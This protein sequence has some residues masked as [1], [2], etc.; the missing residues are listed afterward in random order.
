MTSDRETLHSALCA[1][2][3]ATVDAATHTTSAREM[4]LLNEQ[5]AQSYVGLALNDLLRKRYRDA[6]G[7]F[8][9]FETS[10]T[11]LDG[12]LPDYVRS[13]PRPGGLR[14]RQR[15]DVVVWSKGGG[16]AGLVELK[17]TPVMS[18][19]AESSDPRKLCG[20]LRRW[21]SLRWSIFLFSIRSSKTTNSLIE[22]DLCGKRDASLGR[23]R[24]VAGDF[25]RTWD[26]FVVPAK[27]SRVMW[28]GVL[29]RKPQAAKRDALAKT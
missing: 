28:V 2:S 19:Y 29:F 25:W 17:D 7:S 14:D 15:F 6:S 3:E 23:I 9:T 16:V 11:W 5:W 10:V 8:V 24:K 12:Y 27:G 1:A 13:G 20:A 18:R 22:G 4:D 21:P 26:S